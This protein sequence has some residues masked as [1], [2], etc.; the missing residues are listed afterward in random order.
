MYSKIILT[1]DVEDWFQVENLRSC[2]PFS[3][4][5][6][7]ELRVEKNTHRLLDLFDSFLTET[8]GVS[9]TFFVL[10]WIAERLP[11]LAREI[12]K[13][14]HEVASHGY[15]HGLC[16]GRSTEDLRQELIRSKKFLEDTIGAQVFGYRAPSFSVS[17]KVLDIVR[18]CGYLYDSSYNSFDINERYGQISLNSAR[19]CGTGYEVLDN[20]YELP[21]SNLVLG[22]IVLPWAGGGYFRLVPFPLFRKGV[23]YILKKNGAYVFYIHPW[24]IDHAQPRVENLPQFFKFRHYINLHKTF[25]RLRRLITGFDECQ[26]VSCIAYLRSVAGI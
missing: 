9:A 25:D 13:R 11:H 15:F 21:V 19:K 4:W 12:H 23:R 17:D 10:G 22:K 26:F 7:Y 5:N 1:V 2:I 6:K 3:A 16:T 20:F 24:E 8:G 18:E 14:G